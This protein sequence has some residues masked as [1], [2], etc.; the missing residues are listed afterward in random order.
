MMQHN[1][2]CS[3]TRFISWWEAPCRIV[4]NWGLRC[5]RPRNSSQYG[6]DVIV[7]L[8]GCQCD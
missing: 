2:S 8:A 7:R 1:L 6:T 5:Y 4:L 3:G